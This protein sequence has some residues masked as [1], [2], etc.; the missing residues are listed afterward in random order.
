MAEKRK[1]NKGRILR[2]NEYQQSDGRYFYCYYDMSGKR[3]REYSWKLVSTDKV[4]AGKKDCLSLREKEENIAKDM[5]SGIDSTRAKK[6]TLNDVFDKYIEGKTELKQSTRT[7][8][9]FMYNRYIRD[10]IGNR[11]I[12]DIKYSDIKAFYNSLIE[13]GFK[14]NSMEV[15]HTILHP[16][17]ATAVRDDIINKNPTDGVMTEIKKSHNWDKGKRHALTIEQQTAFVNFIKN[18]DIYKHWLNLFTTFLGTGC[19]VGELIGLR[20][21]DCDFKNRTIS[22]NHNL[23]YRQNEDGKCSFSITTPKTKSGTRTIPML[24]DVYN[25]LNQERMYQMKNGWCIDEIADEKGK[26]YNGF[27]FTNRD[28]GII[29]PHSINRAIKRIYTAYNEQEQALS[30]KEHRE[31]ILIPHFSCHSLRHTFCTRFC[32]NETNVKIIQ[33][34]MGHAD[35]STTMNIYAEATESKKKEVFNNLEG[36][37]KIC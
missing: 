6:A 9:L 28:R 11:K 3:C 1:D 24:N 32:E 20:W 25:A 37:I 17:F 10:V 2:D 34:I 4:P 18:D 30:K 8:Y 26:L 22:I 19:R 36:K 7:N 12:T 16:V 14:P 21:K 33:E 15:A 23:I 31:P 35:I 5:F 13:K 27:V 29:S